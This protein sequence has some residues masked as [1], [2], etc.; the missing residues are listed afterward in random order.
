M[1]NSEPYF[2]EARFLIS[3]MKAECTKQESHMASIPKSISHLLGQL[4]EGCFAHS[5][6]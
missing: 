3:A 4:L 2:E 1:L 6:L 5:L